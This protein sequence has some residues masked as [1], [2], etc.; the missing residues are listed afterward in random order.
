[1]Y[2]FAFALPLVAFVAAMLC[3]ADV[4]YWWA[5]LLIAA[6]AEG[7]I[8]LVF[9]LT[10][11]SKE[12]LSGYVTSVTHH[13]AW[14]ERRETTETKYDEKGNSRTEKKVELI[15]HPDEY[16]WDLNTGKRDSIHSA[17]FY[18]MCQQWG[19]GK[20]WISV[21][22]PNCVEGGDGEICRWDGDEYN[23]RTVTY[24]HRYRNPVRNS[25]SIFRGQR[26][27][28]AEAKSL[29]LFEYPAISGWD[30]PVLLVSPDLAYTGDMDEANFELQHLNAF[31]GLPNQIH[32][33]ILLFPAADGVGIALKQ[34]DYWEGC[35][36]NEF[37]VCLGMNGDRVEW[38]HT[39]SWEDEPVLDAKVK[40]YFLHH[41]QPQMSEFVHWLRD[42]LQL[43]KRKEFKDFE[44]LGWHMSQKGSALY[45]AAALALS[46]I[47]LLCAFWIGG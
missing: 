46:V 9:Y 19:T 34:R 41:N 39:L 2:I 27:G 35:N 42:H 25:N 40:D 30:Q 11:R 12:Y 31:C 20:K 8:Y 10:T 16:Y 26:V 23:T 7:L 44:Y 1:M 6:A 14:V 17:L 29:G 3:G 24:T 28:R 18:Q 5:Y 15:N 38:C 43:W 33:F 21:Y 37:V 36:K 45:W 13:F 47:V 32:V 4:E 22:H